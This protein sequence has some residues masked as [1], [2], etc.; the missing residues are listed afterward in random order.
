MAKPIFIIRLPDSEDYEDYET[1]RDMHNRIKTAYPKLD[2]EYHVLI[3]FNGNSIQ[4]EAFNPK[5][6]PD[7]DIEKLKQI[8]ENGKA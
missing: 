7:I 1:R 4:F 2:D 8:L 5:D 6:I 3:V